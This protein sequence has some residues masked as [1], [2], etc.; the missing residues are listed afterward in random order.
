MDWQ[1]LNLSLQLAFWTVVILDPA[2]ILI[3]R[4]LAWRRFTGKSLVEA[5]VALPLVLL[6]A[7]LD[8]V[9]EVLQESLSG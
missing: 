4:P 3:A 6:F 8:A 7:L 2:A 5:L 1:A 9:L